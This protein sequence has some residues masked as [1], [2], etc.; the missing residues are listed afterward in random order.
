MQALPQVAQA[1]GVEVSD[2]KRMFELKQDDWIEVCK[3]VDALKAELERLK[4]LHQH[5][6]DGP[7][8]RAQQELHA[9]RARC[10]RLEG[11]L[12]KI[13]DG[14]VPHGVLANVHERLLTMCEIASAALS[15]SGREEK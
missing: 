15:D 6:L 8:T 1:Q 10:A 2:Y 13:R 3:E 14:G 12:E 4:E 9:A 7:L 5:M 11:A